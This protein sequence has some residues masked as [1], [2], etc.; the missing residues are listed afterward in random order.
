M[1][2]ENE[3]RKKKNRLQLRA[4]QRTFPPGRPLKRIGRARA[5]LVDNI[6]P[7]Q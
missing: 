2:P 3:G 7:C 4:P 1:A 5:V 6:C